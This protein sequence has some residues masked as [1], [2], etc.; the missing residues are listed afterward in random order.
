MNN[1]V[2]VNNIGKL[3]VGALAVVL[4]VVIA[5]NSDKLDTFVACQDRIQ[6]LCAGDGLIKPT[7]CYIKGAYGCFEVAVWPQ[8][9]FEQTF[10][11]P[12]T[13]ATP[14]SADSAA[15]P[16]SS[17]SADSSL[18][19]RETPVAFSSPAFSPP[20]ISPTEIPAASPSTT[21]V[22]RLG[23]MLGDA[24]VVDA[25]GAVI[26]MVHEGRPVHIIGLDAAPSRIRIRI[27]DG[28]EGFIPGG[29]A[30]D[31]GEWAGSEPERMGSP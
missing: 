21:A 13:E 20:A 17:I 3:I 10:L 1:Q 8:A 5:A 28:R 30:V 29:S 11:Q 7:E 18:T 12:T 16:A 23:R 4:V 9:T 14:E 31:V 22:D 24:N 25:T 2:A 6:S 19:T 15:V 27:H 26:A